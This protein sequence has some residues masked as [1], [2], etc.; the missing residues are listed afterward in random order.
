MTSAR[1]MAGF[2]PILARSATQRSSNGGRKRNEEKKKGELK[3]E[4][5]SK[6]GRKGGREK[7]G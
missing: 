6:T 2:S 1:L 5:R 4:T 7:E 3:E